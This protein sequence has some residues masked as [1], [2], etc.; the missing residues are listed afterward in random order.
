MS[1]TASP[2]PAALNTEI[3]ILWLTTASR[4]IRP[5][6][7]DEVLTGLW[8]FDTTLWQAVPLLQDELERA[9]AGAYPTV[10]APTAD[11]LRSWMG[12]D[13]DGNP[14]VT[15]ALRRKR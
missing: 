7:T 4:T 11:H 3:T 5:E 13:R 2:I 12:G 8:Y 9:L 10:K 15:P 14:K 6:V 1:I